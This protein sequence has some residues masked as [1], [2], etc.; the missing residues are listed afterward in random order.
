[1]REAGQ[2]FFEVQPG[3]RGCKV[4]D[5]TNRCAGIRTHELSLPPCK[6]SR[7]RLLNPDPKIAKLGNQARHFL[8]TL[9]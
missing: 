4:I 2:L 5:L 3:A 6:R 1:L 7:L 9:K 8:N